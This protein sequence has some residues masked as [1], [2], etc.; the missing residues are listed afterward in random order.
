MP[1]ITPYARGTHVRYHGSIPGRQD[2]I[3]IVLG[4]CTCDCQPH[5]YP[6][7]CDLPHYQLVDPWDDR[8]TDPLDL[9]PTL[10]HV[11]HSSISYYPPTFPGI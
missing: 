10:L 2:D 3:L 4:P 7:G 6:D 9:E 5:P 11:R 1:D 8:H